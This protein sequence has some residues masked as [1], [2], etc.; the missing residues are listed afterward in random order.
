MKT[1]SWRHKSRRNWFSVA[2]EEPS[3]GLGCL[4]KQL[5]IQYDI[6]YKP[7]NA[8][9]LSFQEARSEELTVSFSIAEA[10]ESPSQEALT[11]SLPKFCSHGFTSLP[12]RTISLF[13]LDVAVVESLSR[14]RLFETTWTAACQASLSITLYQSLLKLM[15]IESVIPS[16][17]L[18]LCRSLL[19][20]PSI[21]PRIRVFSSKSLDVTI[22]H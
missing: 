5:H 2:I 19:L 18:I 1:F 8:A 16:N 11:C 22:L 13:F 20:L 9:L 15:S 14:V 21:L 3:S 7:I 12:W 4:T 10:G 6:N 17:H